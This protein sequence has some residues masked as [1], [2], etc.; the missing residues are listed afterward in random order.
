MK[1]NNYGFV[2]LA[3]VLGSAS[4]A[5]ATTRKI[6]EFN[7]PIEGNAPPECSFNVVYGTGGPGF[8]YTEYRVDCPNH[9]VVVGKYV[10]T[11]RNQCNFT[12]SGSEYSTSYNN[13][14]NWR[15]YYTD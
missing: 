3:L 5:Q 13:C 9:N 4:L 6:A 11:I 1:K 2:A 15:V 12:T 10:D 7:D 8:L 14:N